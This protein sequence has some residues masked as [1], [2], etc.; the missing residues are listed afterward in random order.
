MS[1]GGNRPP[2]GNWIS[3]KTSLPF[4]RGVGFLLERYL[5]LKRFSDQAMEEV[6]NQLRLCS[7]H[8]FY[9]WDLYPVRSF[10]QF[11][12]NENLGVYGVDGRTPGPEDRHITRDDSIEG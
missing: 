6:W 8:R 2:G 10:V 11:L 12:V 1:T 9:I 5:D 7:D 4:F 3:S